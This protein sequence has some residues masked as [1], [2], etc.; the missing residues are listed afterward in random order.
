MS[1]ADD[2]APAPRVPR[3]TLLAAA[4]DRRVWLILAVVAATL[5]VCCCSAVLGVVLSWSGGLFDP[6]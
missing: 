4:R 6:R 5:L 2:N 3:S 1:T